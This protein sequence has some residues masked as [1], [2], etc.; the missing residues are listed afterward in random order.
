MLPAGGEDFHEEAADWLER[1]LTGR[2][3]LIVPDLFW[4][5]TSNLVWRAVRSQ[6]IP[7]EE[8]LT[9]LK[10]LRLR[11]LE[12]VSS[13]TL[14]DAA[15]EIALTHQRSVYDSLYVALAKDRNTFLITADE[16]L[17]NA[18]AAHL[19]VKWLGAI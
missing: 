13:Y 3:S 17:A 9:M 12:T 16:K 6:R 14:M 8:A 15:F 1:L 7:K 4:V 2:V 10:D 19:P 18:V 5:E 11:N